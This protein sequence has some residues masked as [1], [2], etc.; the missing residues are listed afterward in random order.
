MAQH[1]PDM[2]LGAGTLL[3]FADVQ[4]AKAAGASFAVAPGLNPKT[5]ACASQA[6]LPFRARVF[7]PPAISSSCHGT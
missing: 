6:D 5:V 4:A 2:L 7:A 1:R 3:S